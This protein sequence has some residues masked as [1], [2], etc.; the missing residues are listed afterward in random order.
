M[1][2]KWHN[3]CARVLVYFAEIRETSRNGFWQPSQAAAC[4]IQYVFIYY[5]IELPLVVAADRYMSA[6]L[7]HSHNH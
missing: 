5:S 6:T 4:C 3:P 2:H 1:P 7:G